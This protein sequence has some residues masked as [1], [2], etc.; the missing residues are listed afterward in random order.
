MGGGRGG[1]TRVEDMDLIGLAIIFAIATKHVEKATSFNG[2]TS[3]SPPLPG[4]PVT[5]RLTQTHL[6]LS[7][8]FPPHFT[9]ESAGKRKGLFCKE[10]EE[11]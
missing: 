7:D 10:E 11:R 8:P 2:V 1:Q 3:V 6:L 4:A 5:R 9:P